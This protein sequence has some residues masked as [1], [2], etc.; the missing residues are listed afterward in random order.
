LIDAVDVEDFLDEAV[1]V[2]DVVE[3]LNV[4]KVVVMAVVVDEV[5][6]LF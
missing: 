2:V 3:L 6:L 5:L 4:F 1:V